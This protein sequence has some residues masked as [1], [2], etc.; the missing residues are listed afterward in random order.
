MKQL[1]NLFFSLMILTHSMS[2]FS[3]DAII[4]ITYQEREQDAFFTKEYLHRE[5]NLPESFVQ[6]IKTI[7]E[8]PKLENFSIVLCLK[9]AEQSFT[10]IKFDSYLNK[11][12][13]RSFWA[14]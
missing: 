2:C 10:T 6:M 12:L 9:D 8:C 3:S 4:V 7:D 13:V 1:K 11:T 5:L 14:E